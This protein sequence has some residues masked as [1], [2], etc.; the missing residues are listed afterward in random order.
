MSIRAKRAVDRTMKHIKPTIFTLIIFILFFIFFEGFCSSLFVIDSTI[1]SLSSAQKKYQDYD[2]L[3]GWLT[4]PNIKIKDTFGPN[5]DVTSNSKSFRNDKEFKVEIPKGKKRILCCGD[6]FTFGIGVNNKSTWCEQLASL[7][8]TLE[9][10]N[11]GQGGFGIDQAYLWYMRDG[12]SLD[13]NIH[14]FAFITSDFQRMRLYERYPY[15]YKPVIKLVNGS[16]KITNTPVP[17]HSIFYRKILDFVPVLQRF[18]FYELFT[19]KLP[20]KYKEKIS[21][22]SDNEVKQIALEIFKELEEANKKKNSS[23]VLVYLPTAF[24]YLELRDETNSLREWVKQEA[25]KRNI[26][27]IDLY[28]DYLQLPYE[29][30]IT[31]FLKNDLHYSEEGNRFIAETI[32]KKLKSL[33]LL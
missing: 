4:I 2:K 1:S 26:L 7:D 22:S 20:I 25:L 21:I 31:L 14:L 3:L 5:S 32:Y 15:Y 8:N 18:R 24:E 28:D 10:I 12:K 9:T 13:H 29:K 19:N 33:K 6:S 23:L 11:M 30:A 17:R 16:L 27:F